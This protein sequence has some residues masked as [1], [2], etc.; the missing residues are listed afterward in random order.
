MKIKA[1]QLN[2][3]SPDLMAQFCECLQSVVVHMQKASQEVLNLQELPG[4]RRKE[5]RPPFLEKL[6]RRSHEALPKLQ[7]HLKLHTRASEASP[8][9]LNRTGHFRMNP[10]SVQGIP[11]QCSIAKNRRFQSYDSKKLNTLLR[12]S[13]SPEK[14]QRNMQ[15]DFQL[16]CLGGWDQDSGDQ[17]FDHTFA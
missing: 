9:Q 5:S 7:P 17:W 8:F 14:L 2:P 12:P 15:S 1:R 11:K 13:R 3:R 6:M 4:H 16:Q 10:L